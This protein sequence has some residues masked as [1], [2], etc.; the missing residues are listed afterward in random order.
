MSEAVVHAQVSEQGS[1]S[2]PRVVAREKRGGHH[3]SRTSRTGSGGGGTGT[4]GTSLL[5]G[6]VDGWSARV[7]APQVLHAAHIPPGRPILSHTPLP[8]QGR[9]AKASR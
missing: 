6:D 2:Q 4:T 9:A 5:Y 8:G 1:C 7:A 3:R